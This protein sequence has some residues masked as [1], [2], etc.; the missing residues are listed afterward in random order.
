MS[1]ARVHRSYSG[2]LGNITPKEWRIKRWDDVGTSDFEC[3][4]QVCVRIHLTYLIRGGSCSGL[5]NCPYH[6]EV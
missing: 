4:A 6:C 3:R 5:S 1:L 2:C